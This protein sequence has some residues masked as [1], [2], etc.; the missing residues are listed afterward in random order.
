MK[1]LVM[2]PTYNEASG[3]EHSIRDLLSKVPN[4]DVLVIGA[5]ACGLAAAIAARCVSASHCP[6]RRSNCS[7]AIVRSAA[8][9]D[10][11][12]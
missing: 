2:M 5:G 11:C 4:V 8:A 7:T 9:P 1:T 6:A 12:T 3:I 10:F